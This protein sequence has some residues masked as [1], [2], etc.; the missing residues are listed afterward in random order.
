M[1]H[2]HNIP[3]LF[4]DYIMQKYSK[5]LI[6]T[7]TWMEQKNTTLISHIELIAF[8]FNYSLADEFT[9]Q[10]R[11]EAEIELGNYQPKNYQW[12]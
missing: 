2:H 1:K 11:I 8:I 6:D 4:T 9:T 5:I 12:N 3:H 7:H 10:L